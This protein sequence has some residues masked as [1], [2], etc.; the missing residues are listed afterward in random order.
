MH[1]DEDRIHQ[2]RGGYALPREPHARVRFPGMPESVR[3]ISF[4]RGVLPHWEVVDARYFV[5]LRLA[6]SLPRGVAE[7]LDVYQVALKLIAW[8]PQVFSDLSPVISVLGPIP[9][10]VM[11]RRSKLIVRIMATLVHV[12]QLPTDHRSL[13]TGHF[14]PKYLFG[15]ALATPLLTAPPSDGEP[16]MMRLTATRTAVVT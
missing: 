7:D 5:T 8:L 13:V 10:G 12:K 9:V 16:L 6:N 11:M 2:V 1:A 4:W 3:T 15:Q 14:C